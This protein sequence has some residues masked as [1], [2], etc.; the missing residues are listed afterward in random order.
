MKIND[1]IKA[2]ITGTSAMTAY[3]ATISAVHRENLLLPDLLAL[4]YRRLLENKP[5]YVSAVAGWTSHYV[6]GT[7]WAFVFFLA[8]DRR[9]AGANNLHRI[10]TWGL[11]SG[12]IAIGSW[13]TLFAYFEATDKVNLRRFF[14][15]LV[16]AHLVYS[17]VLNRKY[18]QNQRL[19]AKRSANPNLS[20]R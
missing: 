8:Y 12:L 7:G 16:M 2:G 17:F 15:H 13:R 1:G 9:L 19:T 20:L 3:S 5:P 4:F 6:I 11:L 18:Q 10:L 14:T